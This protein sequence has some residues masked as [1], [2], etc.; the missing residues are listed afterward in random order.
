MRCDKLPEYCLGR[1]H[2]E[3]WPGSSVIRPQNHIA[4]RRDDPSGIII[5]RSGAVVGAI[6]L[7]VFGA[8]LKSMQ[9]ALVPPI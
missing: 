3:F 1:S 4:H 5:S 7:P 2:F 6:A 9:L 8:A